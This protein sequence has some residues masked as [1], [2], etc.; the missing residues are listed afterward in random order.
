ME[1]DDE[2]GREGMRLKEIPLIL[3]GYQ[4]FSAKTKCGKKEDVDEGG[5]KGMRL[6]EKP[7]ILVG[8]QPLSHKTKWGK[9]GRWWW[10]RK[11]R[12]EAE[13]KIIDFGWISTILWYNKK[14][15]EGRWWW[16]REEGMRLK[17]KP[18]I[19]IGCQTFSDKPNEERR[20]MLIKEEGNEWG[21]RMTIDSG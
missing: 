21:W 18:S 19:L 15:K 14:R 10:S 9:E 17:E 12:N 8:C 20:K 7:L 3:I 13:G 5:R 1:D 6:K 4:P 2:V 16:S 11:E